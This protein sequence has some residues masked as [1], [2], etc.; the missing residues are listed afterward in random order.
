MTSSTWRCD[1]QRHAGNPVLPPSAFTVSASARAR[2]PFQVLECRT[3]RDRRLAAS[4]HVGEA[5]AKRTVLW[6]RP[7]PGEHGESSFAFEAE[8]DAVFNAGDLDQAHLLLTE[9]TRSLG[10]TVMPPR[11][12]DR[13]RAV[14]R[15]CRERLPATTQKAKPSQEAAQ[16]VRQ[17]G[18]RTKRKCSR[19]G[20]AFRPGKDL[21]RLCCEACYQEP[22][23]SVRTVSGG[24]PGLGRRR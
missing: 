6:W 7:Q 2:A 23:E 8:F 14:L 17:S 10:A 16:A 20:R 24:L 18:V 15:G 12:R 5:I 22:G 1:D 21:E 4:R 3:C 11:D 9:A 13:A 19:C